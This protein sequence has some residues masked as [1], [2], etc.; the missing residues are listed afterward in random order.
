MAGQLEEIRVFLA[1]A[2]HQSFVAAA[3]HLGTSPPS[4]TRLVGM[5]EQRLGVQLLLRTTRQVSL[6][7]AGAAFAARMRNLVAAFDTAIEDLRTVAGESSGLIRINAPMSMG[8]RILPD[9][10]SQFRILHP[11]VS[12]SLVLTDRLVDVVSEDVDLA[13]RISGE[14]RDKTTIWR[15]LCRVPRLLVAAPDYLTRHGTPAQPEDLAHHLC[16]AYDAEAGPEV[17][18][19]VSGARRR[20]VTAG[21]TLSSNNGDLIAKLAAHG[22]GV[23]L[24]PRFIVGGLIAEGRLRAVLPEW[25]P[26]E[27]WLT[28]YYPPYDRL[29][30]RLAAFSSFF[31]TYVTGTRPI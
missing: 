17:W 21:K 18:D 3:R 30:T 2:E 20:R 7:S 28:L 15:K 4:V 8:E 9:V 27:L 1:V 12:V 31:E 22:E 14:P 13:I 29:P 10:V 26:P 19:L 5:L 16:L 11:R 25:L 6:T 23:A 24:L